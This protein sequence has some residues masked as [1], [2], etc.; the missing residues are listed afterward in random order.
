MVLSLARRHAN[1]RFSNWQLAS[2]IFADVIAKAPRAGGPSSNSRLF[3]LHG[4]WTPKNKSASFCTPESRL[5]AAVKRTHI[6]RYDAPIV[7]VTCH[8]QAF[9]KLQAQIVSLDQVKRGA[10]SSANSQCAWQ[11]VAH[12]PY[13]GGKRAKRVCSRCCP[14][15]A[16]CPFIWTC[17]TA[18]AWPKL[19]FRSPHLTFLEPWKAHVIPTSVNHSALVVYKYS[20]A[21]S[22]FTINKQTHN[23]LIHSTNFTTHFSLPPTTTSTSTTHNRNHGQDQGHR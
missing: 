20:W 5:F 12:W 2:V 23:H 3:R 22:L 10:E 16:C 7:A 15:M 19:Q 4:S 13:D 14:S 6:P 1:L 17:F 8:S 11:L 21:P 18:C 9:F